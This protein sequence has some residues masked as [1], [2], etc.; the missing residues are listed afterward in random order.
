M[1]TSKPQTALHASG[2]R[3]HAPDDGDLVGIAN[4]DPLLDRAQL[5]AYLGVSERQARALMEKRR[6]EVVVIGRSVRVRQSTADRLISACTAPA[7]RPVSIDSFGRET[8]LRV[9][10]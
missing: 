7:T 3:A 1:S 2:E 8:W 6:I 9:I 5:A 10:A 4:P